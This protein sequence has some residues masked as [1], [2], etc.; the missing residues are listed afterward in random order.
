M[1]DP[2]APMSTAKALGI[3]LQAYSAPFDWRRAH[4]GD[5]AGGWVLACTG[6]SPTA[7]MPRH[8][9]A[10]GWRRAL[11]QSG[12]MVAVV[13]ARLQRQPILPTLAQ[14]GDVVMLPGDLTGGTLAICA[15]RTAICVDDAGAT[16]HVP[17]SDALHAWRLMAEH[18]AQA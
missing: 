1:A 2:H 15:G 7:G 6:R 8:A 4:C 9:T 18:E 5:F 11:E 10:L 3:Y 14:V 12:G 13:S 16:V 17:M